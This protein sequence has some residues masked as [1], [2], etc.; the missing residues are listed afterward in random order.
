MSEF[1]V[2][3]V[4][5]IKESPIKKMGNSNPCLKPFSLDAVCMIFRYA[6]GQ[7]MNKSGTLEE[8]RTRTANSDHSTPNVGNVVL[9]TLQRSSNLVLT[10]LCEEVSTTDFI[11]RMSKS[12]LIMKCAGQVI[13][14]RTFRKQN[15]RKKQQTYFSPSL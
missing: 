13:C 15:P 1:R 2:K 14:L 10:L 8:K 7:E 9:G 3:K 12:K 6:I 5:L 4:L 11:F